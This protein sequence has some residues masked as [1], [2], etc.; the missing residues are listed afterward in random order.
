MMLS[1]NNLKHYFHDFLFELLSFVCSHETKTISDMQNIVGSLDLSFDV[2][3]KL[4]V[5][6]GEG[7]G[8]ESTPLRIFIC[9]NNRKSNKILHCIDFF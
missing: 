6:K 1:I 9:E 3:W 2:C 5:L 8:G 7:V 4:L